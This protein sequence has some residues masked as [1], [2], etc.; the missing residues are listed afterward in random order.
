MNPF[1]L[2]CMIK[3]HNISTLQMRDGD[4]YVFDLQES[5]TQR[6]FPHIFH[7]WIIDEISIDEEE[8]G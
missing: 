2:G 7:Q 8:D 6:D 5:I 4:F 3:H 1:S